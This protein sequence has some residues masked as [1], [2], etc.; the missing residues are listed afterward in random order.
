M[1]TSGSR[2]VGLSGGQAVGEGLSE[3]YEDAKHLR[4]MKG[5]RFAYW[6]VYGPTNSAV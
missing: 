5:K 6:C 2:G 1:I 3:W 4:S